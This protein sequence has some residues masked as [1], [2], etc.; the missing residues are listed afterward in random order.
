MMMLVVVHV[1][2]IM[3]MFMRAAIAVIVIMVV[4]H[5]DLIYFFS[6]TAKVNQISCNQVANVNVEV[7]FFLATRLLSLLLLAH[8]LGYVAVFIGHVVKAYFVVDFSKCEDRLNCRARGTG[9]TLV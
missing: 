8:L 7:L 1:R 9:G 6:T 3:M 2:A 4:C 5:N